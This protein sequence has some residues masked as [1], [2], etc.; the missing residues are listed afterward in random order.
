LL[1]DGST[2]FLVKLDEVVA[3]VPG[4]DAVVDEDGRLRRTKHLVLDPSEQHQRGQE[5]QHD[6]PQ[7]GRGQERQT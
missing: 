2:L 5:E 3:V 7:R 1:E 4:L 6:S